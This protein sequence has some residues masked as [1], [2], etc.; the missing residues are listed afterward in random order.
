M[1]AVPARGLV[2]L[3][4]IWEDVIPLPV[5][6]V[7]WRETRIFGS[8]GYSHADFADVAAWVDRR[9]IDLAPIVERQ[10]GFDDVIE[11]FEATPTVR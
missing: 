10:V 6:T 8:Y 2:V 4:G 11:A 7:V 5:S 3:I 1:T 9:E